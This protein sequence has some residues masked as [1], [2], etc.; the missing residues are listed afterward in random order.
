MRLKNMGGVPPCDRRLDRRKVALAAIAALFFAASTARA[1]VVAYQIDNTLSSIKLELKFS[2]AITASTIPQA[3]GSDIAPASGII[4]ADINMGAGTIQM[5]GTSAVHLDPT[6]NYLPNP[7]LPGDPPGPPG[8]GGLNP[9]PAAYGLTIP[10]LAAM[11]NFWQLSSTFVITAPVGP[12]AG[13]DLT[14]QVMNTYDGF[15]ASW[16]ALQGGDEG[17]II[18]DVPI[19]LGSNGPAVGSVVGGLLTIP[20]NSTFT[21]DIGSGIFL[22]V[23]NTGT[24]VANATVPEP[25]TMMLLGFGVVGLLTCGWRARRQRKNLG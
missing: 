8:Y 3:A 20:V 21:V 6:G 15:G 18:G 24:L 23:V 25:S 2:G 4:Y 11:F 9:F 7:T 1:G 19:V 17:D 14:G 5:L 12:L 22:T 13:F 10:G 16:D